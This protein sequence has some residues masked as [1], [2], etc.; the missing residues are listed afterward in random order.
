MENERKPISDYLS[1]KITFVSFWCAVL[2]V[3]LHANCL[4]IF[5]L[6]ETTAVSTKFAVFLQKFISQD[7]TRCAVPIFFMISGY[8]FFVKVR[9]VSDVFKNIKKR[10]KSLFI[11]FVIWNI[12][13]FVI[14]F[15][16][17]AYPNG[18]PFQE[19]LA[20]KPG[21][22]GLA[23]KLIH[24]VFLFEYNA[25]AWYVFALCG[26]VC[27]T[28]LLYYTL[29]N[30][31]VALAC[32]AV[33]FAVGCT[34]P[35]PILQGQNYTIFFFYMGA[36]V[37][38]YANDFV[39]KRRSIKQLWPMALVFLASQGIVLVFG[40]F[41]VMQDQYIP[42]FL[43][44]ILISF[45]VWFLFD[46]VSMP[47][48]K[49]YYKHSFAL[50]ITHPLVLTALKLIIKK[51]VLATLGAWAATVS[52]VLLIILGTVIPLLFFNLIDKFLPKTY[53]TLTGGR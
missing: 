53:S 44:E 8:L 21:V 10:V 22:M 7:L 17:T 14:N 12:L 16:I 11:P 49:R 24:I 4:G 33:F 15:F 23:D 32:L 35:V 42:R 27:L 43:F 45:S 46:A 31:Y 28:P 41:E 26:F 20:L 9:T 6:K 47:E 19:Y 29:K 2:V 52:Y 37:S 50:Y 39:N 1:K 18:V 40:T 51:T 13:H 48:A 38:R 25:V 34:E 3:A 5:E 36:Y 30:K